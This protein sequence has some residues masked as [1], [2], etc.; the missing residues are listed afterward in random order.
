M[1]TIVTRVTLKEGA[2]PAWDTAM[3]ERLSAVRDQ[4]GWI[5]GQ[6]MIPLDKLNQ[7]VIVGTWQT[8]AAWEAW[9]NDPAFAATR[10]QLEGLEAGPGE[11][12]W[13]EVIEDI[14]QPA[15]GRAAA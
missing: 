14:R 1:M 10:R 3:R 11:H 4:A 15:L 8:R 13:H 5:G 9:H 2:E 7:R 12:W 6:L